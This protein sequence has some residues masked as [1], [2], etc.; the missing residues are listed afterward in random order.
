MDNLVQTLES[1]L[2]KMK[3][4][5]AYYEKNEAAVRMQMVDPILKALGW[6]TANPEDVRPEECLNGYFPDYALLKDGSTKLFIEAKNLSIDIEN[7]DSKRQLGKY[8]Y[9]M[10]T[11]YGLL[12]NGSIWILMKSFEEGTTIDERIVWMLDLESEEVGKALRKLST[13]AKENIDSIELL[14]KKTDTLEDIWQLLLEN[15]QDMV[16]SV[17]SVM[18]KSARQMNADLELSDSEIEDFLLGKMREYPTDLPPIK[19]TPIENP[20]QMLLRGEVY[21]IENWFEVLLNTAEWLVKSNI[22]GPSNC[23]V[24]I[25]HNKCYVINTEPKH[26]FGKD[27]RASKRLSNGL[28]VEVGVSKAGSIDLA[29]RLLAK[30]GISR[31]ELTLK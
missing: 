24:D 30:F 4:T 16:K 9:E 28:Y 27:F 5:R 13:I 31:D 12:T 20:T 23:P 11:K 14:M 3:S 22:L 10:G 1:V 26:K 2:T 21:K 6:D 18:A 25:T 7:G 15:P 19:V 29:K 17:A 8:S